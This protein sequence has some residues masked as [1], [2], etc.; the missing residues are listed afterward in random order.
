MDWSHSLA[1]AIIIQAVKDYRKVNRVLKTYPDYAEMLTEKKMLER[2]F[3]SDW[4]RVL[5][6]VN[7]Q[8]LLNKLQKEL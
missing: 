4:F 2:F 6:N 5:T 1:N 7:G 3:L 8:V